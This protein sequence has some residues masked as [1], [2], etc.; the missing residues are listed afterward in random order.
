MTDGVLAEERSGVGVKEART[1]LLLSAILFELPCSICCEAQGHED[2]CP[3]V[4]S[5]FQF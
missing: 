2:L 4:K 3:M 1:R 5:V